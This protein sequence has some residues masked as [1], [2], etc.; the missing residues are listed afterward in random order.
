[1]KNKGIVFNIQRFSTHDGP[2]I[3]T[4]VFLKGCPLT[5]H[6]CSNPES[7]LKKPQLMVRNLKCSGCGACVEVCPEGAL[8]MSEE[9]QRQINW[10]KCNDC[11]D[12]VEAC[13][14]GSMNVSG[15][16]MTVEQVVEE[17]EKDRVFYKNSGGGVTISGGEPMGQTGF[18]ELL[19]QK[20]KAADIH[21]AL[22]T[23]GQ[24][25]Q[26]SYDRILPNVDLVLFDIKQL[27]PDQHKKYI[28][29]SN[30]LIL[31][32]AKF[33]AGKANTWFRIPL[34][35]GFNDSVEHFERVVEMASEYGVEKISLLPFHE[36][37]TAKTDQ[38]G[39]PLPEYSGE[40]PTDEHIQSL[41]DLAEEKGVL[42]TVGS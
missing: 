37:G 19:L 13:L 8:T 23:T 11:F 21:V 9:G 18:L 7:Q 31:K 39:N 5:C 41:I 42:V 33:V 1:M 17:V 36:G 24:A 26:E 28:G 15:D 30:K 38:V 20:L 35:A 27:D 10:Q 2:G 4:T 40:A 29:V 6:W 22:D 34:I 12:C 25:S 3:R 32:N 14:Y 16:E